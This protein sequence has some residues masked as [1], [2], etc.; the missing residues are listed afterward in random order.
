V[1]FTLPTH[2]GVDAKVLGGES[3]Q[4]HQDSRVLFKP[5]MASI[6]TIPSFG[7]A[8]ANQKLKLTCQH[9]DP[10]FLLVFGDLAAIPGDSYKLQEGVA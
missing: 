4:T 6:A 7:W 8:L 9:I 2:P 1:T 5:P 3:Y 10:P